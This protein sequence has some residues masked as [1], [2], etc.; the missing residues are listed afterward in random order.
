M[1]FYYSSTIFLQLGIVDETALV[2]G[3]VASIAFWLGSVAA[4]P[5]IEKI[6]RKKLL[7]SGSIPM[8]IGYCIYTPMIKNRGTTELWIAFGATCVFCAACGWSWLSV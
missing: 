4:I 5:L 2:L 7:I 3:G 1:V 8:L 6:G